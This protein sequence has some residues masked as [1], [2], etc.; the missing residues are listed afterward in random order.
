MG[1][2]GSGMRKFKTITIDGADINSI[3]FNSDDDGNPFLIKNHLRI[4]M[5]S[6]SGNTGSTSSPLFIRG[7]DTNLGDTYQYSYPVALNTASITYAA[8]LLL[9]AY[10]GAGYWYCD[11]AIARSGANQSIRFVPKN[12]EYWNALSEIKLQWQNTGVYFPA[13]AVLIFE[14]E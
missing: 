3:Y 8:N 5:Y 2:G 6:D 7:G 12:A 4:F 10:R 13:G 14:G 1:S 9:E 11:Y